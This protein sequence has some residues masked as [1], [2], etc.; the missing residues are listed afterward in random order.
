MITPD[1]HQLPLS[2]VRTL[3]LTTHVSSA[4][5][6]NAFETML[7]NLAPGLATG[8]TI[9]FAGL[10]KPRYTSSI[11]KS[12]IE[13]HGGLKIGVDM[14]LYYIPLF[15][16]GERIREVKDKRK[17]IAGFD[18]ALST[19]IQEVLLRVLPTLSLT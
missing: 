2:Q 10:C 16:A 19:A 9:A 3:I 13:K 7:R 18:G 8:T 1:Y 5:Q 4:E 6:T 12:T 17:V 11:V 14:N 15:W